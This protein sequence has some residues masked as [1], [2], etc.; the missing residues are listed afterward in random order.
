M[1]A[2]AEVGIAA[3]WKYKEGHLALS[4]EDIQQIGRLRAIFEAAREVNDPSEFL[5]TVK[6][7]LFAMEFSYSPPQAM[8]KSSPLGPLR[9]ILPMPFTPKST[10]PCVGAKVDGRIVPLRYELQN[11]DCVEILTS[12][13]Q[14]PSRDW[15]DIAKKLAVPYPKYD[16]LSEKLNEPEALNWVKRSSQRNCPSTASA[17]ASSIRQENSRKHQS[18]LGTEKIEHLFYGIASG[19]QPLT[20]VMRILAPQTIEESRS[21]ITAFFNRIRSK[22]TSPVL[23]DGEGDVLTSFARCCSPS[24]VNQSLVSLLEDTA[25]ASTEQIA[26]NSYT[27]IP[28]AV[29]QYNGRTLRAAVTLQRLKSS[30]QTK[31]GCLLIWEPSVKVSKSM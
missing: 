31:W 28:T 30:A 27:W 14:Q 18:N 13:N 19:T 7:D 25:S 21:P 4:K 29:C 6:V 1:H 11:G 17:S 16:G 23:I 12:S 10:Y 5:E 24:Q 22:S 2:V 8:S 20:R 9:L 26:S 15:L 3:H